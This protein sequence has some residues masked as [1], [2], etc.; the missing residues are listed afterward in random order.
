MWYAQMFVYDN[1]ACALTENSN[2]DP[3]SL[4]K[5]FFPL[6]NM[7]LFIETSFKPK[8]LLVLSFKKRFKGKQKGRLN[9]DNTM[10]GIGLKSII[11]TFHSSKC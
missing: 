1:C 4:L 7:L 10:N 9:K 11:S 3:E 8:S 6:R 2:Y 5:S